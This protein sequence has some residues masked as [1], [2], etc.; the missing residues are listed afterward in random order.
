M[1]QELVAYLIRDNERV[2]DMPTDGLLVALD[3]LMQANITQE[4]SMSSGKAAVY[5]FLQTVKLA[6]RT[7][8]DVC[9]VKPL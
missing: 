2:W 3:Q 1:K 7:P 9:Q 8:E 6:M 4:Q 5:E